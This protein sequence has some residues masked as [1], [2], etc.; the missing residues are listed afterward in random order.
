MKTFL[1]HTI[2]T[3]KEYNRENW[4]IDRDIIKQIKID[5]E[6]LKEALN[7]YQEIVNENYTINI[8]NNAIKNKQ[9]MFIDCKDGS[10]KQVGFVITGKDE[11]FRDDNKNRWTT[12]FIDLWIDINEIST[13]NFAEA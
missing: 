12:Q 5:A 9:P 11:Y 2:A 13:A 1:F 6:T 7:K 3:M 4:W 8:S 10:T